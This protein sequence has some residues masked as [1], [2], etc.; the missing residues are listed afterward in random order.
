MTLVMDMR[1]KLLWI[2]CSAAALAGT[3]VLLFCSALTKLHE[4]PEGFLSFV[5]AVNLLYGACS[6]SLAIRA[7][8]PL[9]L[10]RLLSIANIAWAATCLWWV[11]AFRDSASAFGL[12]HLLFEAAF[13]GSLGCL[14]W[15]WQNAL[16]ARQEQGL[17]PSHST[18]SKL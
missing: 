12:A 15:R 16:V 13:V 10:I 3:T 17:P 14:E 18:A 7:K 8:R 11:F 6:F 1:Q 2:D 9:P 5:G 4:L